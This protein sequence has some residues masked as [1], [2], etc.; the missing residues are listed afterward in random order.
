MIKPGLIKFNDTIEFEYNGK[1]YQGIVE[2]IEHIELS[3]GKKY[4]EYGVRVDGEDQLFV[5]RHEDVKNIIQR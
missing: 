1:I 2:D 5:I 3:W 4:D